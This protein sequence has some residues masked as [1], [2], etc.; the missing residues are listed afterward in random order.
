MFSSLAVILANLVAIIAIFS[1]PVV[2]QTVQLFTI[3]L[4]NPRE[5]ID[6]SQ[7]LTLTQWNSRQLLKPYSMQIIMGF[8]AELEMFLS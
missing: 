1:Q 3:T 6:L 2:H 5:T 8:Q 7:N 4:I